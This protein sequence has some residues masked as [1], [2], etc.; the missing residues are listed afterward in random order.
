MLHV[1][2]WQKRGCHVGASA[3]RRLPGQIEGEA[4]H[5]R[6]AKET[7]TWSST[8]RSLH[9]KPL[10]LASLIRLM[11]NVKNYDVGEF[12]KKLGKDK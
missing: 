8:I 4:H 10:R 7:S 9:S 2:I 3:L 1:R 5:C 6:L 12:L 11:A